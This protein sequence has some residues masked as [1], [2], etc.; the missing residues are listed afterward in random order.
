MNTKPNI[1]VI[2]PSKTG[3]TPLADRLAASLGFARVSGSEWVRTQ[4]KPGPDPSTFLADITAYSQQELQRNPDVCVDFIFQKYN[5]VGKG[6]FVIEGLRNPR[7]F[8]LLFRPERDLVLFL[9]YYN[10]PVT[11]TDF[12]EKGIRL[13]SSTVSWMVTNKLLDSKRDAWC[14]IYS[15]WEKEQTEAFCKIR[16]NTE[17][18][19]SSLDTASE[20]AVSWAQSQMSPDE[21]GNYDTEGTS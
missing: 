16:N 6:G 20:F 18:V 5:L 8:M 2:G 13:I 3:K 17:A 12:E 10:N 21:D 14:L 1:F 9:D 11:P 4:F 7:D 19:C 15:L